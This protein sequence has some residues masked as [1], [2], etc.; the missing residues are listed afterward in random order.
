MINF[1]SPFLFNYS[2]MKYLFFVILFLAFAFNGNTQSSFFE[3]Q[4]GVKSIKHT[5]RAGNA[6]RPQFFYGSKE[7]FDED[8]HLIRVHRGPKS[9]VNYIYRNDTIIQVSTVADCRSAWFYHNQVEG[10]KTYSSNGKYLGKDYWGSA[11][12]KYDAINYPIEGNLNFKDSFPNAV[13][14]LNL[15]EEFYKTISIAEYNNDSSHTLVYNY[16][17]NKDSS[18]YELSS[19][20]RQIKIYEEHILVQILRLEKD[21]ERNI[22]LTYQAIKDEQG[23]YTNF[24]DKNKLYQHPNKI[25]PKY[26]YDFDEK[27][28]WIKR[29][30]IDPMEGRMEESYREYEYY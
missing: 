15:V 29:T 22:I 1:F 16:D 11:C 18:F 28:N 12:D 27:G 17:L 24:L 4:K 20:S 9:E 7:F 5:K 8:G 10:N 25:D 3:K 21:G 13:R 2:E 14:T 30:L 6:K 26:K 23:T 19:I